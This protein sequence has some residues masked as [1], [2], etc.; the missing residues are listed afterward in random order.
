MHISSV[1]F[2]ATGEPTGQ[3]PFGIS[4]QLPASA[5]TVVVGTGVVAVGDGTAVVEVVDLMLEL[6]HAV[7]AN[8]NAPRS[9]TAARLVLTVDQSR[10]DSPSGR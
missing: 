1:P 3:E 7:A 4:D 6:L 9:I 8:A 10:L 5:G 2:H